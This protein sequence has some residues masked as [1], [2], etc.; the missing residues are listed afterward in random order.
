MTNG[1]TESKESAIN[2]D[3]KELLEKVKN[4]DEAAKLIK[5]TDKMIKISKNDILMITYKQGKIF[6]NLKTDNKFIS[7]V[8]TFKISKATINFKIGIVNFIDKYPRM[9]KPCISLYYLKNNFRIMNEVC[10]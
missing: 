3:V 8:N 9:E 6:R 2:V 4:S 10:Q 1:Q 5:K 7:A